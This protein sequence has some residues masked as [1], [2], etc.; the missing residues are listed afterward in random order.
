MC[1]RLVIWSFEACR[2]ATQNHTMP[3]VCFEYMYISIAAIAHTPIAH[4]QGRMGISLTHATWFR[5]QPLL[6]ELLIMA[7]HCQQLTEFAE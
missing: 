4:T 1:N 5:D 3:A 6:M 2:K 7:H